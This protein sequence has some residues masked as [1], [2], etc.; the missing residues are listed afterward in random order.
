MA[1]HRI[2]QAAAGRRHK[3]GRLG[4]M[5]LEAPIGNPLLV[6]DSF[7]NSSQAMLPINKVLLRSIEIFLKSKIYGLKGMPLGLLC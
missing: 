3:L 2:A 1:S 6:V 7:T 4:K 5:G